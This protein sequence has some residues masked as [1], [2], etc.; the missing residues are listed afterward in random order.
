MTTT[1]RNMLKVNICIYRP[2]TT[3]QLFALNIYIQTVTVCLATG[4][5]P[6]SVD[7]H[8]ENLTARNAKKC[9][10]VSLCMWQEAVEERQKGSDTQNDR[11][12]SSI[13]EF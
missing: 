9:L 6:S 10:D 4:R 7:E 13:H 5:V 2:V 1:C 3:V 8:L 12:M 11:R